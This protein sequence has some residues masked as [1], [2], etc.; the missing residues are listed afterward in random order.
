MKPKID[1]LVIG[2]RDLRQGIAYVR[3]VLGAEM[4]FGGVHEQMGTHNHLMRLGEAVFLEV[5]AV[6]PDAPPLS[7]P[8]WYGLDDPIVRREIEKQPAL[9]AWVI[10]TGDIRALLKKSGVFL[11]RPALLHRGSLSWHFGVTDDGR[12]PAGGMLPYVIEWRSNDPPAGSMADL[13]CR[14]RSLEIHHPYP[15]WLREALASIEASDLVTIQELPK[16]RIP[17]LSAHIDTP[18]GRTI[19]HRQ[20]VGRRRW[21]RPPV[22]GG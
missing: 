18:R 2:A 7:A 11:G 3:E 10:N 6:N 17:Y 5:I 8:R 22:P 16:D 1:H 19:L 13:G 4:P 14:L 9:L 12:L 21:R 15:A 20:S